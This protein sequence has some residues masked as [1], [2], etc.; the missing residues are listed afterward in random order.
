MK[1]ADSGWSN[2][3]VRGGVLWFHPD[4]PGQTFHYGEACYVRRSWKEFRA[5]R[6][7]GLLQME[8]EDFRAL[9]VARIRKYVSY[10]DYASVLF[11]RASPADAKRIL[12]RC[13]RR[14]PISKNR[15]GQGDGS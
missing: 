5:L 14:V 8:D 13:R 7:S 6:E 1:L 2:M 12:A 3:P 9:I 11:S 10:D 15:T 4:Y